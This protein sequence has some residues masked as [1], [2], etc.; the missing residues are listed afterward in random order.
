MR[1]AVKQ[2]DAVQRLV[3]VIVFGVDAEDGALIRRLMS[4]ETRGPDGG[5]V[6]LQGQRHAENVVVRVLPGSVTG[7]QAGG[8]NLEQSRPLL[9]SPGVDRA[10]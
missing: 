7:G 4:L 10:G 9:G 6:L 3:V 5:M 8:A 2:V 1:A